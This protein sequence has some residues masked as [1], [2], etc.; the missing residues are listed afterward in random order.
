MEEKLV[1][2]ISI[3]LFVGGGVVYGLFI[4]GSPADVY[5]N[6]GTMTYHG[7]GN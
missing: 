2:I 4:E 7:Q 3:I 1:A 5:N 6:S